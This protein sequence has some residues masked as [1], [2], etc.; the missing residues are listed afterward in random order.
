MREYTLYRN[1]E[2][3]GRVLRHMTPNRQVRG[4]V[5]DTYDSE[6]PNEGVCLRYMIYDDSGIA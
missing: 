3:R 6:S 4:R 5:Q 2:M 1:R